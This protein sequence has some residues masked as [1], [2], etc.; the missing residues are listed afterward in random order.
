MLAGNLLAW[1]G[2]MGLL[3]V[4]VAGIMADALGASRPTVLCFVM[5]IG[6]FAL[7]IPFQNTPVILIFGLLYGFTF[8]ITAPLTVVF[9]GNIYGP[10]RLGMLTGTIS[11][12]HQILGGLG[13]FAGGWIYDM[14]GNYN[15]AF[16]LMLA[17]SIAA[18]VLTFAVREPLFRRHRTPLGAAVC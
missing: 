9:M 4:F 11:M 8:L 6:I 13:A 1:M 3:G 15:A 16:V 7:I 17:L 14:T 5:R 2:V 10:Q 18:T 12:I